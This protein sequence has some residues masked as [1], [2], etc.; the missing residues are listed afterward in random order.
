MNWNT[1]PFSPPSRR[2]AAPFN[3][4]S[5]YLK[6]YKKGR[7]YCGRLSG[8]ESRQPIN[9]NALNPQRSVQ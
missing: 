2:G 3:K 1:G 4:M 5:R 9:V 8:E 6:R 7:P